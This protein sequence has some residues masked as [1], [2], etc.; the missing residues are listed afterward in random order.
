MRRSVWLGGLLALG[1]AGEAAASE[2]V[3][4]LTVRD[5]AQP[6]TVAVRV[7]TLVFGGVSVRRGIFQPAP[8]GGETVLASRTFGA[9]DE[10]VV[11]TVSLRPQ[12]FGELADGTYYLAVV[13]EGQPRDPEAPRYRNQHLV[14]FRV[15]DGV[16]T[17]LTQGQYSALADPVQVQEGPGGTPIRVQ[18]GTGVA[19]PRPVP[20]PASADALERINTAGVPGSRNEETEK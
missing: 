20:G 12:D 7:D 13:A 6:W 1:L 15:A 9:Q 5:G 14:H 19:G 17:R 3:A 8:H 2:P 11:W 18:R 4:P 16:P 10:P